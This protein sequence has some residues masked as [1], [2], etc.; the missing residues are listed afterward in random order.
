MPSTSI[1]I[2]SL[3]ALSFDAAACINGMEDHRRAAPP[4]RIVVLK[5]PAS[6]AS[7][8]ADCRTATREIT[9][10]EGVAQLEVNSHC[11]LVLPDGH[12]VPLKVATTDRICTLD[13]DKTLTCAEATEAEIA[14]ALPSA[15]QEEE[16]QSVPRSRPNQG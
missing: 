16:A 13:D 14:E 1:V 9:L 4:G 6:L 8:T 10:E 5:A 11:M 2:A 12:R 15:A 7:I 3:L